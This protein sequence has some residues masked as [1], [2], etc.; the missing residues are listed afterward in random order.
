MIMKLVFCTFDRFYVDEFG[1][2]KYTV[3]DKSIAPSRDHIVFPL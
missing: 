2:K 1:R 3:S